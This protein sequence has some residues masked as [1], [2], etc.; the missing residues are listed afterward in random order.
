MVLFA[1]LLVVFFA[2]AGVSID[3][4]LASLTQQQMQVAVD[5]AALE[6]VRLRDYSVYE[7]I[8]DPNRRPKVSNLVRLV[9]DDDL[10]PTG[11]TQ[12]SGA[13]PGLPPDD[14]DQ[15]QLGA[16]PMLRVS[17]QGSGPMAPGGVLGFQGDPS[18]PSSPVTPTWD[19]PI[20]QGNMLPGPVVGNF[21][22]G[23][24][25]SGTY[26]DDA[27][28]T[29]PGNYQRPDFTR[30]VNG[31][32]GPWEALGFLVRM[33]R[34][35][36]A[37][38][39]DNQVGKA[40]HGPTV[41]LLFALG[42][43][44]RK[45]DSSQWDPRR[46]GMTVRATAIAVAR[47][48]LRASPAPINPT[49]GDPIASES[50]APSPMIGLHAAAMS[51]DYWTS[52]SPGANWSN[53]VNS[54]TIGP[55]GSLTAGGQVRGFLVRAN[56]VTSVGQPIIPDAAAPMLT[57]IRPGYVAIYARIPAGAGGTD[58][59]I[60]YGFSD[61]GKNSDGTLVRFRLGIIAPGG[62][63]TSDVRVWVAANGVSAQIGMDTPALSKPDWDEVFRQN[64]ILAFGGDNNLPDH[65][66]IYD[67]TRIRPGT[68]LAPALAR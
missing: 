63:S 12:A 52:L 18:Q 30:G 36:G 2:I 64:R 51:I 66:V 22:N 10:H 5:P 54:L 17:G 53:A 59:V 42:S 34:T 21:D 60:G 25:V 41:P 65:A 32:S 57:G 24:M 47:P 43:T 35:T 67:H 28:H 15:L 20:L 40:S 62:G 49:T 7:H 50:D 13:V 44:L 37:N 58:R 31:T 45:S 61:V 1:V 8:S 46:D 9:F 6:G 39:F 56:T 4:G 14:A 3:L 68:L 33:R 16:G 26:H 48:A 27:E 11:G 23:D 19:D 38:P 29:E 55:D